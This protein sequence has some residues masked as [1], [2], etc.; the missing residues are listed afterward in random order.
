MG[1]YV[2]VDT[3]D[4]S[5]VVQEGQPPTTLAAYYLPVGEGESVT[6]VVAAHAATLPFGSAIKLV[7]EA[8]VQHFALSAQLVEADASPPPSVSPA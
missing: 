7:D 4:H 3:P 5:R 8:E 1:V 2:I 6:D